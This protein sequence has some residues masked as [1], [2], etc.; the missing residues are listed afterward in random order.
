VGIVDDA[1]ARGRHRFVDGPFY[2]AEQPDEIPPEPLRQRGLA[3]ELVDDRL[4]QRRRRDIRIGQ[5]LLLPVVAEAA[6]Q[7][8][9]AGDVE[10]AADRRVYVV[11]LLDAGAPVFLMD[12]RER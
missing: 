8:E 12:E 3:G 1:A 4:L 10:P 11:L 7:N 9:S 2:R 6:F 5:R